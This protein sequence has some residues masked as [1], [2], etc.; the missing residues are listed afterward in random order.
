[1][2]PEPTLKE[3]ALARAHARTRLRGGTGP[4]TP[5]P[6]LTTLNLHSEVKH[7]LITHAL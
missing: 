1:M 4:D 7:I 2:G 5:K 6:N 3:D